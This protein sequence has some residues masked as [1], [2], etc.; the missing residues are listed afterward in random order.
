MK[1]NYEALKSHIIDANFAAFIIGDDIFVPGGDC[2]ITQETIDLWVK[3]TTGL[4]MWEY[5]EKRWPGNASE[6]YEVV[7]KRYM[8]F[9]PL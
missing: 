5:S 7:L 2:D 4:T 3:E 1:H 8:E 6:Q 9:Y